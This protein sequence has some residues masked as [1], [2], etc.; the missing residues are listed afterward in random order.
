[1]FL[2]HYHY[3]NNNYTLLITIYDNFHQLI[4]FQQN[5]LMTGLIQA[6]LTKF[7]LLL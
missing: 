5:I 3:Q 2:H 6:L 7:F 1:M 4:N